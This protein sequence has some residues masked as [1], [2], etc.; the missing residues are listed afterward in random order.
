MTLAHTTLSANG[1]EFGALT[2]GRGDDVVLCIHG[3]PDCYRSFR[4]QLP[5]LG[6]AGYH[7]VAPM[8]RGYE[9]WSRPDDGAHYLHR[10]AEDV[11]GWIDALGVD[12]AHVVGHDWGAVMAYAAAALAPDR[13]SSLTALAIPPLHG[14][15]EVLWRRPWGLLPLWY[16]ALFQARGLAERLVRR[17]ELALIDRLWRRWSPGFTLPEPERQAIHR[18]LGQPAALTAALTYYRQ[19]FALT[20]PESRA[21]AALLRRPVE[22]PTLVLSGDRDGCM[23][24]SL[25]EAAVSRARFPGGVQHQR[26]PDAGHF[27][28]QERP[29]AVNALLL[30]WLS[31]PG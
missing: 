2:A 24:P 29:E 28:H 9:P 7:A 21:A 12:R 25:Y 20:D 27:L 5:A 4:H 22:V 10:L 3:F 31:P 30:D 18:V 14:M 11:I 13:F 17:N 16:M 19:L 1:L 6:A 26:V 15:P 23:S 8:I